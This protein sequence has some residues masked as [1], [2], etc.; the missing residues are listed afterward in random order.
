VGVW[1][2]GFPADFGFLAVRR[3]GT[4]YLIDGMRFIRWCSFLVCFLNFVPSLRAHQVASVELEFRKLDAE[5]SL[6]GEMDVAYMLPETRNVPGGP[7]LSRQAVMRSSPAELERIRRETEAT[8]RMLLRFTFAGK[9]LPWRVEFP[10]FKKTPFALPEEAGDVA[11]LS[12][13]LVIDPVDGAGDLQIHWSGEQ[14]TELIVM[15]QN[16]GDENVVSVLPGGQIMLL[17]QEDS[18]ESA[19]TEKPLTGGWVQMGFHHVLPKGLDH[20]LFIIGLFLL[21]PKWRPLMGQSLLFTVAHSI[22][23]ALAVFS[24]IHVPS[25]LVEILIAVS[26]AWIGIENLVTR[27]LGRQRL[28]LVF[29]FGLLHGLGFASVLAEK[30]GGIPRT[31]LVGPLL[32]FNVGVELAQVSV[33]G[34]AFLVLWPLR[35]WASQLQTAGSVLVAL[36]GLVWAVQRTFF[37]ASPIF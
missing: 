32:G 24:V 1:E 23:L 27:K 20:L 30:L 5:W 2:L 12:V 36:A 3:V 17:K 26:I 11:L 37:P 22:T 10:D 9:E 21:L 4:A 6:D 19:V 34:L 28:V 33:L 25:R 14:E 15:S 13:H 18:G 7:P 16:S 35:K 31:Q 29:C 8:L